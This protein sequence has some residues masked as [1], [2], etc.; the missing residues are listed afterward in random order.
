M[1]VTDSEKSAPIKI[2]DI[3]LNGGNGKVKC[4]IT[5]QTTGGT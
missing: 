1:G 2:F 5:T 3:A 4:S